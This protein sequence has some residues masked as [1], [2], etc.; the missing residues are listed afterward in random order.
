MAFAVRLT[1]TGLHKKFHNLNRLSKAENFLPR[2]S[3]THN[4][5]S[6]FHVQDSILSQLILQQQQQPTRL[7]AYVHIV[8]SFNFQVGLFP[9]KEQIL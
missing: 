6:K 3:K 2:T 9:S 7:Y 4:R 5:V 8:P 1:L